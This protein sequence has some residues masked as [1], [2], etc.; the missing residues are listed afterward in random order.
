[1]PSLLIP[2]EKDR[3]LKALFQRDNPNKD[4]KPQKPNLPTYNDAKHG[5]SIKT[6]GNEQADDICVLHNEPTDTLSIR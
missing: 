5:V 2:G 4:L 6:S 3:P 1:L